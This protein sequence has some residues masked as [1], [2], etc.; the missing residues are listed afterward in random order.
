[1]KLLLLAVAIS[2][3]TAA[4]GPGNFQYKSACFQCPMGKFSNAAN[5]KACVNCPYDSVNKAQMISEAGATKC[6]VAIR[7]GNW[8]MADKHPA[9]NKNWGEPYSL[10]GTNAKQTNAPTPS[11]RHTV[12]ATGNG[13][14]R[15]NRA[16]HLDGSKGKTTGKVAANKVNAV[17]TA[18]PTNT[19]TAAP[20][21]VPLLTCKNGATTVAHG[22]AG[23]GAAGNYCNMCRCNNGELSCTKRACG[24]PGSGSKCK[25]V[26]CK[27]AYNKVAAAYKISIF[28]KNTAD[29][30]PTNKG[31]HMA[32]SHACGY[33]MHT[34][35]CSCY[36]S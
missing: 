35:T 29:K 34:K 30:T 23:A 12:L 18:A 6:T 8:K 2:S 27:Y 13:A 4:C 31:F 5:N 10:M 25:F 3:A 22:W 14:V 7:T 28:H 17:R 1:M 32:K 21:P 16:S 15:N 11:I 20:T 19:P 33:N 9:G 24:A 36:C 26:A